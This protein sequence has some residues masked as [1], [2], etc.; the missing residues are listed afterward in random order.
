MAFLLRIG[1]VKNRTV[2]IVEELNYSHYFFRTIV[3]KEPK[4]Q[5]NQC[6]FYTI[7]IG[8]NGIK[9][10]PANFNILKKNN[11]NNKRNPMT[12]PF[13]WYFSFFH[14]TVT[15]KDKERPAFFDLFSKRRAI[16]TI[17]SKIEDSTQEMP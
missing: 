10:S 1:S 4:S 16:F 12:A 3:E 8:A 14:R 11:M 5:V 6:I 17:Y 7:K 15:D 2:A 9:Q 13:I